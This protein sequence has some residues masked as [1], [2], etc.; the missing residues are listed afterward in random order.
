MKEQ[1]RSVRFDRRR[2]FL[3]VLP[4][5]VTPFLVFVVWVL[6]LVG[7]A[8]ALA[9]ET[10]SRGLNMNLPAAVPSADSTWDKLKFYEQAD[11]DSAQL[12]KLRQQDPYFKKR[13]SVDEL[14]N[15]SSSSR[16]KYQPYPDEALRSADEEEKKVYEKISAIHREMDKPSPRRKPVVAR[17]IPLRQV[18]AMGNTDVDRL[19]HM[20]RVMNNKEPEEDPEMQQ[21]N[22]MIEKIMDIQHPERVSERM[23][24]E[25]VRGEVY[26]VT[27]QPQPLL[28]ANVSTNR[29]YSMDNTADANVTQQMISA[30]V[31][32]TQTV[33]SGDLMKMRLTQSLFVNGFEVMENQ[34]VYGQVKT[35]GN[36]MQVHIPVVPVNGKYLPVSM[37]VIGHDGLAGIPVTIPKTADAASDV[38]NKSAQALNLSALDPSLGAQVAGAVLQTGKSLLKKQTKTVRYTVPAGYSVGL[39]NAQ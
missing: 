39:Q 1:F 8:E 15:S 23:K 36:R 4:V 38:A 12:R 19:E 11:K 14:L 13:R 32:E 37:D 31:H 9:Q 28:M 35:N 3:L 18:D 16:L 30:V 21:I 27:T 17:P 5:I 24:K 26:E 33:G 2:R 7:P 20:M 25:E 22:A 34:I 29:F 10:R 6:G